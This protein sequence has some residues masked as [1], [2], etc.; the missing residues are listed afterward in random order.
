MSTLTRYNQSMSRTAFDGIAPFADPY[1]DIASQVVPTSTASMLRH[2]EW[3]AVAGD[4]VLRECYNRVAAY[5][6]T[7][8]ELDGELGD[9]EKDK[10][11][12][13]LNAELNINSF[14]VEHGL[15]GLV[16]GVRYLSVTKPFTRHLSCPRCN[17]NYRFLEFAENK[18]LYKFRWGPGFHGRC[19][20]CGYEGAFGDPHDEED[21]SRPLNL[22]SWNPHDMRVKYVEATRKPGAFE[23]IIPA[24]FR[25]E[26]KDGRNIFALADTPWPWVQ[27]ALNDENIEFS[28][29]FVK[30][31]REPALAGLRFRG[32]GVPRSIVNLRRL[33]Y[34]QI[35]L[36]MNEVLAIG[37]VVPMRVI[38]PAN[39]A[40]RG[41]DET[42]IF[43]SLN[44]GDLRSNVMRMVGG[45]RQDPNS[46]HYSP[47]P[48]Q[49]QA[50]GADARQ[51]IPADLLNQAM[52]M[53]L[54]ATGV[55]VDLFKMTM[56]QQ[57]A[58]VGLRLF[59]RYWSP[60][61]DGLNNDLAFLARRIQ[62]LKRW[63]KASYK[64]ADTQIVDDIERR[65]LE[66]QMAQAGLL[67]RGYALKKVDTT[68]REQA[69]QKLEDLEVE[70]QEQDRA[71]QRADAFS[72][73]RQL[74]QMS[75][76]GAPGQ[77]PAPGGAP[78]GP[79]GQPPAD[80]A[81]GGAPA[82][83]GAPAGQAPVGTDPLAGLIPQPGQK[84]DPATW[85]S[86]AQSATQTLLGMP[87]G[88]RFGKLQEIKKVNPSFHAFVKQ[89][90][91]EERSKARSA[92]G[93]QMMQ[94]QYGQ[95]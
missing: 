32:T 45:H 41:A 74:A 90:M 83:G 95:G 76:P 62:Y 11:A 65:Q 92:G 75:A 88:Q 56:T 38:S 26:L 24:D 3:M 51:L 13:Y 54:N 31:W 12:E 15:S 18:K 37:H 72:F 94:Q 85:Y 58:P 17:A 57:A 73:S 82:P 59:A 43:R 91:T 29:E 30:Y 84:V 4:G 48:L 19:P 60:F 87:E 5:F 50:L 39:T 49:M 22:I 64:F 80:P 10:Q 71:T 53:E 79:G 46:I 77:P 66:M 44:V 7:H 6:I 1:I 16:Y 93:A 36:R 8:V 52:E 63:E 86:Q 89:L 20:A 67:A 35:L 47:V 33:Y 81:Q 34:T 70:A 28:P 25:S 61:V 21:E 78:P 9:D 69:R 40:G 14:M 23:W 55:P 68:I 2:A 42:D 27:A